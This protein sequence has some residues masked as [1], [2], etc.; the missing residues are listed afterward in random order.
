MRNQTFLLILCTMG[1][2]LGCS[3]KPN[4]GDKPA[5][6]P[7]AAVYEKNGLPC[8][9]ELCIGDGLSELKKIKWNKIK[10]KEMSSE[11]SSYYLASFKTEFKGEISNEVSSALLAR[12]FDAEV[13]P[14]L[15]GITAACNDD[16]DLRGSYTSEAGNEVTVVIHMRPKS[17][18]STEQ[19]WTV[20]AMGVNSNARLNESGV[21][22]AEK[23]L[24]ERYQKFITDKTVPFSFDGNS[25]RF[26]YGFRLESPFMP[27]PQCFNKVNID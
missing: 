11:E 19:Q 3:D 16:R 14:M 6:T 15:S 7:I 13:V 2:L 1:A 4:A 8:L 25:D 20:L 27:P 12:A 23:K 5:V 10:W 17:K 9:A 22:E 18:G 26:N 24:S 21:K